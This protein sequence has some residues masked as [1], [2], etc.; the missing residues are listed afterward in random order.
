MMD[1]HC[2]DIKDVFK[3]LKTSERGLSEKEVNE[4]LEK[5]GYNEITK[6]IEFTALK[7]FL[8]QFRDYIIY[9]LLFAVFISLVLKDFLDAMVISAILILNATLGFFQEYKTEKSIQLLKKSS[10]PKANVIRNGKEIVI[11]ANNIVIGDIIILR[12]GE[13]IPADARIFESY[14]LHINESML[15][16]ESLPVE[17]QSKSVAKKSS[18]AEMSSMI[19]SSTLITHGHGRAIVTATGMNTEIG[20][21]TNLIQTIEEVNTPLQLKTKQ[22]GKFL[23][24]ISLIAVSLIF[25]IGILKRLNF[26]EILLTSISLAVSVIPEGLPAIVT[27][28][29]AIGAQKMLKRKALI[30]DLKAIE[31][32]GAVTVICSDKTGTLTKNEMTITDIFVNNQDIKVTGKGYATKGR[33]YLGKRK[34]SPEHLKLLLKIASSCNNATLTSGDPTEIALLIAAKKANVEREEISK[35]IPFDPVKKYMITKHGNMSY[36][37]GAPENVLELC[38]NIQQ[39]NKIKKLTYKEKETIL[40]KNFEMA[41]K[42]LRVLAFA[43][44]KKDKVIFVGLAG[45]IDPPRKEIKSAIKSCKKAGIKVIMITGDQI[46]T[47]EVIANQIGITGRTL[48][49]IQLDSMNDFELKKEINNIN[50]FARVNPQHKV[51]IL[52]ALQDNGE[53][54]A[55]TGDGVNDAPALKKADVGVAMSIKGTDVSREAADM[56]LVDDNFTSIVSAIKE[57]RKIYDNIKK[58]LKFLLCSNIDEIIVIFSALVIGLPLPLLP[59]HILWI[60]LIT[61]GLPALA[62]LSDPI[63]NKIM[64]RKPR[65]SKEHILHGSFSLIFIMGLIAAIATLSTYIFELYFNGN[66]IDKARTMA[67]TTSIFFELFFVFSIRSDKENIWNLKSNKWLIKVVIFS[68]ILHLLIIYTSLNSLFK[69]ESLNFID[70]SF[71]LIVSLSGLLI[72]EAK[73]YIKRKELF[74]NILKK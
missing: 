73:K 19:F 2:S 46:T 51:K 26:I 50:I 22:L 12:E 23:G 68:I 5:Y 72:Y 18:I 34:I 66:S 59:I 54:V 57:G 62:L 69:L 21:I 3:S 9:I 25:I 53:V 48:T 45:M 52:K 64:N 42:A 10:S 47:A 32:L 65:K 56:V 37:K 28:A 71:I 35:E 49:G 4:R 38:D 36:I 74:K 16:G 61:D 20:K 30:R 39:F 29:L 43:Y 63:D 14:G 33:F 31:T 7:I 24:L 55:M 58:S 41:S 27:I 70:W 1:Y 17:K 6:K 13:K 8:K 11:P 67:L 40:N 44:K 60:N 15:T